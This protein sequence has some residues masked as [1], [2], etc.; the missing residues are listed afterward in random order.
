MMQSR[1]RAVCGRVRRR[2]VRRR[3]RSENGQAFVLSLLFLT[4]LLGLS[5]GVLDVGVWYQ[6]QRQLQARVDAAALAG[7]QAL[8]DDPAAAKGLAATYGAKNG[9][10]FDATVQVTRGFAE[11][12]TIRIEATRPS[13]GFLA[14]IVG[15]KTIKVRATAAARGGMMK[16]ARGASPIAVD[17]KHPKLQC[18]PTP[19]FEQPT[20]LELEKVGPGAFRLVNIDGS[21]GGTGPPILADWIEFGYEGYMPLGWYNSDPG[22]KFNSSQVKEALD[23]RIGTEMLYPVY[24]STRGQGANFEYDVVA[25]V[26]YHLTGYEIKGS[27]NNKLYGWFTRVIW[28]GI[29]SESGSGADFGVRVVS[30][31]E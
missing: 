24:R 17:E 13:P 9:G 30:L 21:K 29:M 3:L 14:R 12:D 26:G 28:E 22:A 10:L 2:A 11:N 25:W 18:K 7:A 23:R 4:V 20:E 16:E 19:C 15:I 27:K 6:H 31:V 5:A 1:T 8:P